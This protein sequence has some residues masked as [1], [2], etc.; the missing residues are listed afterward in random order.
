MGGRW[1]TR[2]EFFSAPKKLEKKRRVGKKEEG[3]ALEKK[4]DRDMGDTDTIPKGK[5]AKV[6]NCR[7]ERGA[8]WKRKK[9]LE[10]APARGELA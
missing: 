5:R 7:V 3:G 2:S 8:S 10:W 1:S 9:V 6:W 4:N